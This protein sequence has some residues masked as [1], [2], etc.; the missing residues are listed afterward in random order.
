MR[1]SNKGIYEEIENIVLS[2]DFTHLTELGAGNKPYKWAI[3][4]TQLNKAE[5]DL[6]KNWTIDKT[7]CIVAVEA[8]EHLDSPFNFIRRA[9]EFLNPNG[10]LIFSSPDNDSIIP[11][12][13]FLKNKCF[14]MFYNIYA[15][16]EHLYPIFELGIRRWS[17]ILGYTGVDT[18]TTINNCK[19]YALR[20]DVE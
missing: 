6:N 2:N 19:I 20:N 5:C 1:M 16:K 9:K 11:R 14:P 15:E 13:H 8:I 18:V 3:G 17:L 7:D 4:S 10:L 12:L